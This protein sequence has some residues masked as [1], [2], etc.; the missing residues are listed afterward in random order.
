LGALGRLTT[1]GLPGGGA[2][3]A[4]ITP[5]VQRAQ[6]L[7]IRRT[8]RERPTFDSI[9]AGASKKNCYLV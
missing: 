6:T 9:G 2:Q 1:T 8:G 7:K 3:D 5:T 4:N